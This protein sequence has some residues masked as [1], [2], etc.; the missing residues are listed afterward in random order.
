MA[1][2]MKAQDHSGASYF[3]RAPPLEALRTVPSLAVT[4][5]GDHVPILDPGSRM[6]SQVSFIDIARAYFNAKIDERDA[7]TFVRLLEEDPDSTTM[8]AQLL[9]HMYGTRMAAD[10]KQEEYSTFLISIGFTQGVGH[11]NFFRNAKRGFECSVHG[12]DFTTSGPRAELDWFEKT[13]G[14][15]YEM[16]IG[17]RL[18]PGPSD[19]KG[20]RALNRIVRWT[21]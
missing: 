15:H 9:K 20:A 1:R 3:A 13:M 12:D 5:I 11:A 17:P 21:D 6:R 7:P 14:Q 18:G 8:C 10:G 2:Q 16:T 19:A 4:S